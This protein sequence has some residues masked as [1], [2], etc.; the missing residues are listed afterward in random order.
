MK[1]KP[2]KIGMYIELT[3]EEFK[4]MH[5]LK[6]KHA[7]NIT[8]FLKNCICKRYEELEGEKIINDKTNR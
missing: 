8:R 1:T 5:V 3:N 7:I 6:D 2:K 4:A